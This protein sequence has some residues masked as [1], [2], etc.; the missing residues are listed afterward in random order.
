MGCRC[1]KEVERM[2]REGGVGEIQG[3]K[4]KGGRQRVGQRRN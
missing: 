2:D 1:K 3:M 4:V